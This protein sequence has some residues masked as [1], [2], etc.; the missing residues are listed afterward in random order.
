MQAAIPEEFG[1]FQPG[2]HAKHA[3]LL[4][5]GQLG[6]KAH[7]VVAGAMNIFRSQLDDGST[8]DPGLWV[9]QARPASAG[10]TASS[11]GHVLP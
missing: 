8:A 9:F 4:G 6:L 11:A 1:L 2:D 7:H 10:R 3:L 5:V